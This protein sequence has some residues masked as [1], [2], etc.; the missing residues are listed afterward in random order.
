MRANK[1]GIAAI[2]LAVLLAGGGIFWSRHRAAMPRAAPPPPPPPAPQL[3]PP[4]PAAVRAALLRVFDGA[5]LPPYGEPEALSGDFNGDGAL[6]LAV[7]VVPGPSRLADVNDPYANWK[8]SDLMVPSGA[9]RIKPEV[10][11][12]GG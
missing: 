9:D 7:L 12:E 3:P 1:R 11:V 4:E 10:R 6:D 8:L 5:V 2:A